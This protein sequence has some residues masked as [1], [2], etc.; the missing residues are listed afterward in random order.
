MSERTLCCLQVKNA[1]GDDLEK[2]QDLVID[3]NSGRIDA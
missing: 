2:I 1:S 3:V